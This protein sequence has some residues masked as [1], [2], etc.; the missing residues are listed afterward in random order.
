MIINGQTQLIGIIGNPIHHTASPVMHNAMINKLNLNMIY[1]PF[2]V[3]PSG[4]PSVIETIRVAHIRGVNVTIPFKEAV[5]PLLDELHQDAQS[6]GAVNTI[7]NQNGRLIGYNTD[8]IGFI[9][10]LTMNGISVINKRIAIIGAG[11]AARAICFSL[12]QAGILSLAI[13][14][15]TPERTTN[16]LND[17]SKHHRQNDQIIGYSLDASTKALQEADIVINTTPIGMEPNTDLPIPQLDWVT[18]NHTICDIVYKPKMTRFLT[19]AQNRGAQVCEGLGM[20]V[21]QGVRAFELFTGHQA[22]YQLMKQEV[23]NYVY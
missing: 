1:I 18:S 7:I 12:L 2:L 10:A 16:L 15:R 21:G 3:E 5:I 20:L 13:I 6:I 4:L 8:G 9:E 22:D 11:G 19:E 14:N 17:L 23:E